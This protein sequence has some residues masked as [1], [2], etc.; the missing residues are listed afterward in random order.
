M[1]SMAWSLIPAPATKI[2]KSTKDTKKTFLYSG[3]FGLRRC[4]V[5][6]ANQLDA[7]AWQE[8]KRIFF[9]VFVLFVAFVVRRR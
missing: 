7:A 4:E 6:A 8:E 3:C 9:E 1:L 5:D 2:T